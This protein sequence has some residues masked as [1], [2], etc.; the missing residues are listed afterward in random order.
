[1]PTRSMK[2]FTYIVHLSLLGTRILGCLARP[3]GYH[4]DV[5][6]GAVGV[7]IVESNFSAFAIVI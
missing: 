2:S 1:M 5:G 7:I 6:D 4:G 3:L